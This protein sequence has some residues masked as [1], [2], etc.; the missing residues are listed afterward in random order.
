MKTNTF[1]MA[2]DQGTIKEKDYFLVKY[3]D[4]KEA[5]FRLFKAEDGY[6]MLG[7]PTIE[8]V[9]F[10]GKEGY[11]NLFTL[12]D[13]QARKEYANDVF[14]DVHA[15]SLPERE[16]EFKTYDALL[17]ALEKFSK[18]YDF[19]DGS[20]PAYALASR[21]VCLD[22]GGAIFY[23][24]R[25]SGGTVYASY[26]YNSG[27]GAYSRSY[28]VR[29]EAIPKSTME[30]LEE[31]CDG[32]EE[33]PWICLG[34]QEEVKPSDHSKETSNSGKEELMKLIREVHEL[35]GQID[36]RIAEIEKY[37]KNLK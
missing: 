24:F 8:E 7:P 17:N 10:R 31:D 33:K 30:F 12:A 20:V 26:L 4:G 28:A 19:S 2:L 22:S 21:C 5:L 18:M 37:V 1:K 15:C 27:N 29:P 11:D 25:V 32:S 35:Q 9:D 14:K 6:V 36:K 34:C 13:S 16:Y 23:L 3:P